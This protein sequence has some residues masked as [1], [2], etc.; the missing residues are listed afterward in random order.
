MH[1]FEYMYRIQFS[2]YTFQLLLH[3]AFEYKCTL[4]FCL[5]SVFSF[6]LLFSLAFSTVEYTCVCVCLCLFFAFFY[7][8]WE[9]CA[10]SSISAFLKFTCYISSYPHILL[11]ARKL[12]FS[13]PP[14]I[15]TIMFHS[16]DWFICIFAR[17]EVLAH[18]IRFNV[19]FEL[20]STT[21]NSM[22]SY[23]NNFTTI[24]LEIWIRWNPL[25]VV[26]LVT[27]TNGNVDDFVVLFLKNLKLFVFRSENPHIG[28]W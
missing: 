10:W 1:A 5:Y 15:F 27:Q 28:T 17:W 21:G 13:S 11:F 3:N 9:R 8:Q 7:F 14:Y 16:F 25:D 18:T 4:I 22:F 2:F 24:I 23:S 19:S 12:S 26:R 20:I 6:I